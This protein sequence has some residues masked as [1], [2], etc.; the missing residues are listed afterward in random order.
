MAVEL[1]GFL[2]A[3]TLAAG[4]AWWLIHTVRAE[5]RAEV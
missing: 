3:G 2:A 1:L 5:Q 4:L